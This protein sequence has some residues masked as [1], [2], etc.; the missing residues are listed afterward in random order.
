MISYDFCV[1]LLQSHPSVLEK[2]Q[3]ALEEGSNTEDEPNGEN[4]LAVADLPV[5]LFIWRL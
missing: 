5:V 3:A 4:L 2:L 1:C